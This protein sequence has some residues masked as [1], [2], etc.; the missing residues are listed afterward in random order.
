V[1]T[2]LSDLMTT[3]LNV[4]TEAIKIFNKMCKWYKTN[5]EVSRIQRLAKP[6]DALVVVDKKLLDTSE[7]DGLLSTYAAW[8]GYYQY[9]VILYKGLAD[10][11]DNLYDVSLKEYLVTSEAE[12]SEKKKEGAAKVLYAPLLRAEQIARTTYLNYKAKYDLAS[13]QHNLISRVVTMRGDELR[14]I[15]K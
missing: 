15:Q 7:L 12:S 3:T 9:F 11:L 6:S 14:T 2:L 1:G 13:I 4:E 8:M 10:H 5:G